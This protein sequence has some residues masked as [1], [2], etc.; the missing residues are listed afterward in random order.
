MKMEDN[1][2]Y[3]VHFYNVMVSV[4]LRVMQ[5][6]FIK[7]KPQL[8]VSPIPLSH[9]ETIKWSARST[10]K[11]ESLLENG[12]KVLAKNTSCLLQP[13]L[14]RPTAIK[15]KGFGTG[16]KH[17]PVPK[18]QYMYRLVPPTGTKRTRRYRYWLVAPTGA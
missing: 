4:S 1:S 18:P 12:P 2:V 3:R 9:H 17:Y 13:V 16:L 6:G 10:K 8:V 14:M 7:F 5:S 15:G 11:I